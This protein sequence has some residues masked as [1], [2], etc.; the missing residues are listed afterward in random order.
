M[1][2]CRKHPRRKVNSAR[3]EP[4]EVLAACAC[5]QASHQAWWWWCE[6]LFWQI[7]TGLKPNMGFI[8]VAADERCMLLLILPGCKLGALEVKKAI[9]YT[10]CSVSVTHSFSFNVSKGERD[11]CIIQISTLSVVYSSL[12]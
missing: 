5:P 3:A 6:V 11:L 8:R 9:H 10:W 2:S 4:C 1:E 12:I 7:Q